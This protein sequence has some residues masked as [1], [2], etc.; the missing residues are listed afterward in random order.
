MFLEDCTRTEPAIFAI[1]MRS[2]KQP[3][4]SPCNLRTSHSVHRAIF[5]PHAA[6]RGANVRDKSSSALILM[7]PPVWMGRTLDR[8]RSGTAALDAKVRSSQSC[9]T[10]FPFVPHQEEVIRARF[11]QHNRHQNS[12]LRTRRA[13]SSRTRVWHKTLRKAATLCHSTMQSS[14]RV[15]RIVRGDLA[16]ADETGG[17]AVKPA[18]TWNRSWRSRC[19]KQSL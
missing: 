4:A 10:G 5:A 7:V 16:T 19:R 1:Y 13:R 12:H 8:N 9:G 14:L 11:V 17:C 15:L 3:V 2:S 18:P 6:G